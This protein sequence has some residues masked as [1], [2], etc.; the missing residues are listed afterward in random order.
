MKRPLRIQSNGGEI[1]VNHKAKIPGYNKRV[2]FSR[3]AI[4]NIITQKNLTKQYIVTYDSNYQMFIIHRE[5]TYLTN[6]ENIIH[7]SGLHYYEPT[8]KDLVFLNTVSKNKEGFSKRKIKSAV[9]YQELQHTLGFTTVK[10]MKRIIRSNYIQDCPVE[11]EDVDND[12]LVWVKDVLYLKG[13]NTRKK[14][15]RVN[16]DLI[17]VPKDDLKTNKYLFLFMN[18]FL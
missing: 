1:S 2:W 13:K 10:E 6:M 15:I 14:P 8:K 9:K 3:R 4:T 16:E 7:D 18:I 5:G 17:K 11:T 12:E